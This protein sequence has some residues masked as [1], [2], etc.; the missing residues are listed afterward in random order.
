[1]KYLTARG[2]VIITIN[3][4]SKVNIEVIGESNL[5]TNMEPFFKSTNNENSKRYTNKVMGNVI[6]HVLYSFSSLEKE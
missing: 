4:P 6:I 2:A 1:M 5:F 3:K